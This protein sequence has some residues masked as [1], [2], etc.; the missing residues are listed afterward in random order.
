[1]VKGYQKFLGRKLVAWVAPPKA[2]WST[3]G[4]AVTINPEL[5]LA[6]GGT[7]QV[8]KLYFKDQKLTKNRADLITHLMADA[9]GRTAAAGTEFGVLDVRHGNLFSTLAP[10]PALRPLL[11]GEAASFAAMYNAL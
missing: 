10:T 7:N 11:T 6:I 4:I 3:G 1:L 5:G 2:T 9:L 8:L